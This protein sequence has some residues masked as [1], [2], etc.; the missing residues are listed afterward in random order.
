MSYSLVL[1][2]TNQRN[3]YIQKDRQTIMF[4]CLLIIIKTQKCFRRYFNYDEEPLA[5]V[6]T[7]LAAFVAGSTV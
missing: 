7:D 1:Y 5:P 6:R 3:Y 4:A 2:I